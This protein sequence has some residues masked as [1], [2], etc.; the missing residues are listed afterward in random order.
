MALNAC[1]GA[2]ISCT[3]GAAASALLPTPKP[4]FTSKMIA[5]NIKDHMPMV[6]VMPFGVCKSPAN[7]AV[8]AATAAALGV[9]TPQPCIPNT[10]TPWATGAPTVILE[11]APALNDSSKLACMWGGVISFTSA[12]QTTHNIA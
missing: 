2:K 3:M 9:L 11:G 6:N 8:A 5:A 1:T 10:P 12:A 7:P 4:V